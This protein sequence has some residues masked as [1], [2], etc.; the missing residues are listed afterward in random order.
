MSEWYLC[1]V[2]L[3]A[4][5]QGLLKANSRSMKD[6]VYPEDVKA[7]PVKRIPMAAQQPYV[8]LAKEA[9]K[10]LEGALAKASALK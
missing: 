5:I 2:A 8:D 9:Y 1:A 4:P 6:D 10:P 7:I 3:S